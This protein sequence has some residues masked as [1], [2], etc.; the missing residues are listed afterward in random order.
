[1]ENKIDQ[2]ILALQ[3]KIKS[4]KKKKADI[5]RAKLEGVSKVLIKKVQED[6]NFYTDLIKLCEKYKADSILKELDNYC[7][8]ANKKQK[9]TDHKGA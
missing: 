2:D 8:P 4:L 3:E 7:K 9:D 6:M 5:E 1:M